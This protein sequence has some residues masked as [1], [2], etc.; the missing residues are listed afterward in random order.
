MSVLAKANIKGGFDDIWKPIILHVIYVTASLKFYSFKCV[1]V[2][3]VIWG[4]EISIVT[5][6]GRGEYLLTVFEWACL[7]LCICVCVKL[8]A[9]YN[10]LANMKHVKLVLPTM[11]AERVIKKDR[12]WNHFMLI[13]LHSHFPFIDDI[14]SSKLAIIPWKVELEI[15]VVYH[16]KILAFKQKRLYKILKMINFNKFAFDCYIVQILLYHQT[17]F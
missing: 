2:I 1:Y 13:F 17:K 14:H 8:N 9:L 10:D 6:A 5:V 11:I 15:H 3:L 7:W 12:G 4:G 16:F